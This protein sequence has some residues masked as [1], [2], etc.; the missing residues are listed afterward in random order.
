MQ[1]A[2]IRTVCIFQPTDEILPQV[3]MKAPIFPTAAAIP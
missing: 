1:G 2:R 3:P